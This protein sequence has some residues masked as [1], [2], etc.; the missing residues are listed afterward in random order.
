MRVIGGHEV[1]RVL[2]IRHIYI[3]GGLAC[4]NAAS[5]LRFWVALMPP[6][7]LFLYIILGQWEDVCASE[8]LTLHLDALYSLEIGIILY[9][10][11]LFMKVDIM[12][13]RDMNESRSRNDSKKPHDETKQTLTVLSVRL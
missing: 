12:S 7:F 3:V 13:T 6:T 5:M 9:L 10:N 11:A 1:H 4:D 8:N 2:D